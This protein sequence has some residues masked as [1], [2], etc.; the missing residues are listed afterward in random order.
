[1]VISNTVVKGPT[2]HNQ[3]RSHTSK[4][5]LAATY[6]V[7][8]LQQTTKPLQLTE[9]KADVFGLTE[10]HMQTNE[11]DITNQQCLPIIIAFLE[12]QSCRTSFQWNLDTR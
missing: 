3:D 8:S 1:M 11:K 4:S 7:D 6:I 2:R 10:T 12:S 5:F 9:I